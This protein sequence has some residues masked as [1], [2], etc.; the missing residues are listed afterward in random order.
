MR[1]GPGA[2]GIVRARAPRTGSITPSPL[3][4]PLPRARARSLFVHKFSRAHMP[5][6]NLFKN[7]LYY[8]GFAA[9]VAWP[10]VHPAFTAP[11]KAQVAAGAALW[12]ASQ[13]ANFAVH[14]Q[15]AGMRGAE[16]SDDRRPPGGPLFALVTSPNYTAEV[17]GWVGWTAVT[18]LTG[19]AVFTAVGF[20][21]MAQW[22]RAKHAGYKK[23]DAGRAYAKARAAI[24]P[25]LL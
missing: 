13:A 1:A 22:A 2:R 10:L 16:G 11:G 19:A 17:L 21:Q 4:P 9:A 25:F 15:L 3:P 23:T 24:V 8:W 18:A 6:T 20:A 14:A 5:L 7:S 12:L